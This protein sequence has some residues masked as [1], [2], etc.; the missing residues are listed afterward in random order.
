MT[1]SP[2]LIAQRSRSRIPPLV[3]Q[4]PDSVEQ[5]ID[6]W[7]AA[8]GAAAYMAGGIDL[9]NSMK[10]GSNVRHLVHLGR[11]AELARIAVSG[12]MLSVGAGV[13][14][15]QTASSDLILRHVPALAQTCLSLGNPRVRYKGTV[16][17]NLMAGIATYDLAPV[18]IALDASLVWAN[19]G[20]TLRRAPVSQGSS[21]EG[22][23]V[24]IELPLKSQIN[25]E[26]DRSLRPAVSITLG[27]ETDAA[28]VLSVRIGIGCAYQTP[29]AFL[30]DLPFP[31]TASELSAHAPSVA[32]TFAAALPEP[33]DDWQAS[34]R[35]RR[36]LIRVLLQRLLQRPLCRKET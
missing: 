10:H 13:T 30:L 31:L 17:G 15:G 7:L 27:I 5:A 36:R 4:R 35:F 9:V 21:G 28:Q 23:L 22:L 16:G 2:Q 3:L 19:A 29:R 33:L 1:S 32:A 25:V 20:G 24:A 34:T 12:D 14:H 11:I 18:L 8:D 26:T 6:A